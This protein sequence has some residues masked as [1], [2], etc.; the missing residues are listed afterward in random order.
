MSDFK[1]VAFVVFLFIV[2]GAF[3][4]VYADTQHDYLTAQNTSIQ[5]TSENVEVS[6]YDHIKE[7][8]DFE[9]HS[10]YGNMFL[11][12]LGILMFVVIIRLVRG[13]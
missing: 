3:T 8:T 11:G 12:G 13:Q 1:F 9:T 5:N 4:A 2:F 10:N 7:M 6:S